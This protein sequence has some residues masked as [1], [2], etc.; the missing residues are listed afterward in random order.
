MTHI[1]YENNYDKPK[2][3]RKM[4]N[5]HINIQGNISGNCDTYH[6]YLV[7]LKHVS[8]PCFN[9]TLIPIFKMCQILI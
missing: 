9:L 1:V 7:Y 8:I 5:I 4:S 6:A 3:I 2:C